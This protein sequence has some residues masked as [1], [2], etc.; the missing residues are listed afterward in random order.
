MIET[1]TYLR[2]S[3]NQDS[4]FQLNIQRD[5]LWGSFKEA[6]DKRSFD[7]YLKPDVV[8][9]DE[10]GNGEGAIDQGG[11]T[12]ELLTLLMEEAMKRQ[13]WMW[14]G[15]KM[16]D[17]YLVLNYEGSWLLSINFWLIIESLH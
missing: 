16:N 5:N 15:N 1:L 7:A 17:R 14:T 11:P 13:V 6:T 9:V 12:I 4:K 8:F 10:N 3:I 2:S